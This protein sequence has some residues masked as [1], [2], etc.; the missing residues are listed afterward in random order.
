MEA[1]GY[2]IFFENKNVLKLWCWWDFPAGAMV[3]NL[4]ANAEDMDLIP[5]P[6]RS[7][8]PQSNG[9]AGP[10]VKPPQGK[11]GLAT[12]ET[13]CS[14]DDPVQPRNKTKLCMDA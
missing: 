12:R 10:Q 11:P 4:P 7:H 1:K 3:K 5:D 14:E 2:R 9:A 8:R 13:E 6:G